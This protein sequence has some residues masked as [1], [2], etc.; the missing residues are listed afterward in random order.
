[1]LVSSTASRR[2]PR[3]ASDWVSRSGVLLGE[4]VLAGDGASLASDVLVS[5]VAGHRHE[6]V[7]QARNHHWVI[8]EL[9][10]QRSDA[11]DDGATAVGNLRVDA[12]ATAFVSFHRTRR[13]QIST[14][15][16]N[17]IA[18]AK[19]IATARFNLALTV[20]AEAIA[21][22]AMAPA[23]IIT[24]AANACAMLS[25]NDHDRTMITAEGTE[26]AVAA[27]L[28]AVTRTP[29]CTSG[30]NTQIR[31]DVTSVSRSATNTGTP[32]RGAMPVSAPEYVVIR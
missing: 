3:C 25:T 20:V 32:P 9:G 15:G 1:M 21:Q 28:L 30:R 10:E 16:T 18:V 6:V 12:D 24:V 2:S 31:T 7:G 13:N 19:G 14:S 26:T 8:V 27:N 11:F 22:D 17:P 29:A 23:P 5:G 4:E